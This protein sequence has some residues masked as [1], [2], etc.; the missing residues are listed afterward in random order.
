MSFTRSN[1]LR[2]S[3]LVVRRAA[4]TS[5]SEG[6]SPAVRAIWR[7]SLVQS[8][9]ESGP[10][11]S[12]TDRLCVRPPISTI[13]LPLDAQRRAGL[14]AL[15]DL[16]AL[17]ALERRHENFAAERQR[18]EVDRDLAEEIQAI[19]A[20]ELVLLHVDDDVEMPRRAAGRS[21]RFAFTLQPQ[22]LARSDARRNLHRDLA[23]LRDTSGAETGVTR[24]GRS[25]CR[26]LGTRDRCARR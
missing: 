18:G 19:A 1:R 23:F 10:G 9:L 16:H 12:R 22:L 21:A 25:S 5:L 7:C 2:S 20:E 6:P 15:G 8:S 11:R 4:R 26:R 3:S 13:P 17:V 14:S 24:L